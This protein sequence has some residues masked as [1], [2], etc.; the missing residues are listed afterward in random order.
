M[1]NNNILVTGGA[2]YIG[3]HI[4]D[5]LCKNNY[6]VIVLDNL[7]TGYRENLNSKAKFYK[8]DIL[9]NNVLDFIFDS[10]EIGSL[11][12]LAALKSSELS[13]S[14]SY[15]Y[16]QN[17]IIGSINIISKAVE[18]KV[19]KIIFSSSAAVYG[20]PV[21]NPIDEVHPTSPI[22]Y[23]GYTKLAVEKYLSWLSQH[24]NLKY[25]SLRY[26][27]AAGYSTNFQLKYF[28]KNPQN[29]IP[30]I[31][32]VVRGEKNQLNI[33]GN[34]YDTYD[35]TCIRDYVNVEDIS[36]A[37]IKSLKYLISNESS[38]INLS[39]GRGYS[40]LDVVDVVK[41][42]TGCEIPIVF[43]DRRVGDPPELLAKNEKAR[44][45]LNW[46]PLKSSLHDIID[47]IWRY[48]K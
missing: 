27:N 13:M 25:I 24:S 44:E 38:S 36:N 37:H 21:Y 12:H 32:E 33:F 41:E 22:N 39:S 15:S 9:N 10:Y 16:S 43:S 40:V 30:I 6:N 19:G 14:D 42:V 45:L 26:F 28:E 35:G 18:R 5:E 17:N 4:V 8:G 20:N 34:D 48:Y 23:Y 11:I 1:S 31:F 47:S 2:G 7:V 3:S 29:L 46:Q